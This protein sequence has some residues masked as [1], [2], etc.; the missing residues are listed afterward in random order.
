[1]RTETF[2]FYLYMGMAA[3]L[4]IVAVAQDVS[5]QVPLNSALTFFFLAILGIIANYFAVAAV[6]GDTDPANIQGL[7]YLQNLL[8]ILMA[9]LIFGTDYAFVGAIAV[10]LP[11]AGLWFVASIFR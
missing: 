10:S 4:L 3:L 6:Q 9:I 11:L 1:M 5:F 8:I 7:D 2:N